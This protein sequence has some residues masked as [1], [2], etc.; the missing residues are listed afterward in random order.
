M[1]ALEHTGPA[2]SWRRAMVSARDGK[3]SHGTLLAFDSVYDDAVGAAANSAESAAPAPP[4]APPPLVVVVTVFIVV[5][6][7]SEDAT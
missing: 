7:V 4:P 1:S 2:N 3:G 5:V 6:T